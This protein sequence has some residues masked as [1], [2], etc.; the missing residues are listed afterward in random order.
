[1][2][3]TQQLRLSVI[4]A[5]AII[6]EARRAYPHECCGLLTGHGDDTVAV[7]A[8]LPM[9]NV[10]PDPA[11]SFAIDPQQHFDALREARAGGGHVVGHYH[12]HP[13]GAAVPSAHD[14]AMAH[15]PAAMW[16]IVSP[17]GELKAYRR[18]AGSEAFTE[19]AIVLSGEG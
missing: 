3:P 7:T 17:E 14:L 4:Q 8:V 19:V 12:S 5:E 2:S 18:P 13:R 9:N 16:L 11:R 6:Q 15:D 10:S 1:M